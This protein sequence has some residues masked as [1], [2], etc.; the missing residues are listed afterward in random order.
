MA[1]RNNFHYFSINTLNLAPYHISS[2]YLAT[3]IILLINEFTISTKPISFFKV[4][5]IITG[6]TL[7]N[8][9]LQEAR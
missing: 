5:K 1:D 7:N 6:Q 9:S 2:K 3:I 8:K 4:K